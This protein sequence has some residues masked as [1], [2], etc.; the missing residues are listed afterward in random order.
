MEPKG[1]AAIGGAV[2]QQVEEGRIERS[3][4][5]ERQGGVT[6]PVEVG[7]PEVM[8]EMREAREVRG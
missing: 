4:E 3:D 7:S 5:S 1:Q 6:A 2:G 8:R